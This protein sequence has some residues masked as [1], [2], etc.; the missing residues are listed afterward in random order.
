VADLR[1]HPIIGFGRIGDL[2]FDE[3]WSFLE[4]H[5]L[6]GNAR[7]RAPNIQTIQQLVLAGAGIGLL[8]G[9]TVQTRGLVARPVTGLRAALPI[10]LA[11]RRS[12][13]GIPLIEGFLA[14]ARGGR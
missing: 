2:F 14:A 11:V 12:G 8:P 6:V 1:A 10:W 7:I 9:Y 3:V 13:L 4:K 5:D